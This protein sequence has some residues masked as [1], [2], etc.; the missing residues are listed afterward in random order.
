MRSVL[1]DKAKLTAAL[2]DDI[3][4]E[5]LADKRSGSLAGGGVSVVCSGRVLTMSGRALK[6]CGSFRT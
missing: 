5:H 1:V 6:A 4:L 2:G 3:G